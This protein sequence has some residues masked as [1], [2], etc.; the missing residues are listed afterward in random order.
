MSSKRPASA[1]S[2]RER[3]ADAER[4]DAIYTLGYERYQGPRRELGT[5]FWIIGRNVIRRAWKSTWGVKL[6]LVLASMVVV[7]A[8]VAMWV[9]RHEIVDMAREAT[10]RA[11]AIP[12]MGKVQIPGVEA[13]LYMSVSLFSFLAFV[14]T[15]TV[16][17]RAIADD[18]RMGSFQFYFSRPLRVSDYV[19]GKLAGVLVVIGMP[20][21]G[22]PLLLSLV[23]L[24]FAKGAADA[25]AHADVIPRAV[26][27]GVVGTLSYAIIGLALG[28]LVGRRVWAQAGFAIY[29]LVLGNLI[30]L[31]AMQIDLPWLALASIEANL[32]SLGV[33]LFDAPAPPG[34]LLPPAWA[35][36]GFTA[37]LVGLG[38]WIIGWRI[39]HAE[40]AALGGSS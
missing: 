8:S 29:Y 11:P 13:A 32:T 12:G 33:A 35:A 20:M 10:E 37:V 27:V 21:L 1:G 3:R 28:A 19:A 40:T 23:R 39:R 9:L 6:P 22:G 30:E 2:S 36:A 31:A 18:L 4:G 15:T 26:A 25:W 38:L 5:R 17:C 34:S 7:G 16:G 24:L 14:L